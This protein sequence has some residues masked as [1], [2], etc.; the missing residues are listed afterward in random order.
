MK[1]RLEKL[2]R[3]FYV[4]LAVSFIV[5]SI[6]LLSVRIDLNGDNKEDENQQQQEV[7]ESFEVDVPENYNFKKQETFYASYFRIYYSAK[8]G[9]YYVTVTEGEGED[10]EYLKSKIMG[11]IRKFDEIK[12]VNERDIEFEDAREL[13]DMEANPLGY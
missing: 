2:K 9:K 4:V 13:K 12:D 5:V 11:E 1:S 8:K 3:I 7:I 10:F 6:T